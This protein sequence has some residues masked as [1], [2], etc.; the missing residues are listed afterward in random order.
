MSC[1]QTV[2]V[3]GLRPFESLAVNHSFIV[4]VAQMPLSQLFDL[5]TLDSLIRA[6][7]F[8][9]FVHVVE[10]WWQARVG[11]ICGCC[12]SRAAVFTNT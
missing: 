10:R 6:K 4:D 8:R 3:H 1:A 9:I 7:I 12:D 5:V 11:T 2:S